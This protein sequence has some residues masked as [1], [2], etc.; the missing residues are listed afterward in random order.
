MRLPGLGDL[1][2]AQ[3]HLALRDGKGLWPSAPVWF[4]N[5]HALSQ[6]GGG[7]PALSHHSP[8][9]RY[10][11][12]RGS[13]SLPAS[14]AQGHRQREGW[15]PGTDQTHM[16]KPGFNLITPDQREGAT[17]AHLLA[18]RGP[19][20]PAPH[21]GAAPAPL[22][23]LSGVQAHCRS[24]RVDTCAWPSMSKAGQGRV[25]RDRV[26]VGRGGSGLGGLHA[27]WLRLF[28]GGP[29]GW[30]GS[31]GPGAALGLGV[32]GSIPAGTGR[33]VSCSTSAEAVG[34]A[35]VHGDC[36]L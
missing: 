10:H 36:V 8:G 21:P 5:L 27:F 28:A 1:A 15:R 9:D 3:P 22:K 18:Q 20:S 24:T 17:L 26:G 31:G 23:P 34:A 19:G 11:C 2:P 30:V 12:H 4:L 35:E 25:L 16:P 13:S 29:G 7:G 14:Q 32:K 6:A 33:G